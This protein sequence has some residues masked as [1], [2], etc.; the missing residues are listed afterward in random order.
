[1][2]Y[3]GKREWSGYSRGYDIVIVE[4]D[5]ESEAQ[6]LIEDR[7]GEVISRNVLRDDLE[8]GEVYDVTKEEA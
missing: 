3:Q 6:E 1:M 2:I 8:V 4:A 7:E 5:S